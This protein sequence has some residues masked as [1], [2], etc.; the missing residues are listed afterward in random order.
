MECGSES[1]TIRFG[2]QNV[3]EGHVYVK[4]HYGLVFYPFFHLTDFFTAIGNVEEMP[5]CK[6]E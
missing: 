1:L 3:F 5:R 2:T 4:G 6:R